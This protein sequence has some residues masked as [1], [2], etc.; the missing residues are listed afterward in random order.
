MKK[1]I[2]LLE[3]DMNLGLI[4]SEQLETNGYE[5]KLCRNGLEGSN[6]Y[7]VSKYDICIVDIMMPKKN[8]YEVCRELKQK[9]PAVPVIM[10]TAKSQEE[11]IVA[12][13]DLGVRPIGL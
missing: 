10:L 12:G 2:L 1:K 7:A 8:G 5:V 9:I 13:L 3:D 4:L 11:D 6:E